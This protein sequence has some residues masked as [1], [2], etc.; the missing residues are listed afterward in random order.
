MTTSEKTERQ[1]QTNQN[2]LQK[3]GRRPQKKIMEDDLKKTKKG[4]RPKKI[5]ERLTNQPKST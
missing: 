3:Y 5:Y 1:T 2:E 4:R